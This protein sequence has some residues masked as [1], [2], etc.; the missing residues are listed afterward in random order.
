M[1][2]EE[3]DKEM[4]LQEIQEFLQ[5]TKEFSA[6]QF[7][8]GKSILITYQSGETEISTIEYK[9]TLQTLIRTIF[10][11]GY[12]VGLIVNQTT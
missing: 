4:S 5:A 11:L 1:S 9:P 8:D 10:S 6:K 12:R 3:L 7:T 2:R